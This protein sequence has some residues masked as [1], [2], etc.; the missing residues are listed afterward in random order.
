MGGYDG[1]G[2]GRFG[3][4]TLIADS[5]LLQTQ[6]TGQPIPVW[7][8]GPAATS[9]TIPNSAATGYAS[10]VGTVERP[11]NAVGVTISPFRADFPITAVWVRVRETNES[12]TILAQ[13]K[14]IVA[15][16]LRAETL[17]YV[18]LDATVS[19]ATALFV[20]F[21]CNGRTA[22]L[23]NATPAFF[24]GTVGATITG[25]SMS[26][27]GTLGTLTASVNVHF[28]FALL[29]Y[30]APVRPFAVEDVSQQYNDRSSTFS[31]WAAPCGTIASSFDTVRIPIISN[32]G[33][34]PLTK[35]RLIIRDTNSSGA[36]LAESSLTFDELTV[37]NVSMLTFPLSTTVSG[38][39]AVWLE[40][41][42]DGKIS[43]FSPAAGTIAS[44][45]ARYMTNGALQ[46]G[47]TWTNSAAQLSLFATFLKSV[48]VIP[49]VSGNSGTQATTTAITAH[50]SP[51]FVVPRQ[52]YVI[53]TWN[54]NELSFYWRQ[55]VLPPQ[56]PLRDDDLISYNYSSGG[57]PTVV[58]D[59]GRFFFTGGSVSTGNTI[60][61]TANYG[62]KQVA[63]VTT[64]LN[65]VVNTNGTG[66]TRKVLVIGDS[67]SD[68]AL[69]GDR[70]RWMAELIRLFAA[71]VM[72]IT[73][74]GVKTASKNDS[75][76]TPRTVNGEGRS[77]WTVNQFATDATSP[78]VFSSTFNFATYLST[79]SITM[80]ASD[81]VLFFLGT[82]DIAG[83]LSDNEARGIALG[84]VAQLRTMITSIRAAVSGVRV[85]ICTIPAGCSSQDAFGTTYGGGQTRDRFRRNAV[86][87]NQVMI[88]Q[89]DDLGSVALNQY[90]IPLGNAIDPESGY[91]TTSTAINARD[92]ATY[93]KY[94]DPVHPDA[95]GNWQIADA[96]ATFIKA[97]G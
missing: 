73:Q 88:E 69:A 32:S 60:T 63:R 1:R 6:F 3:V 96:V 97:I 68:M 25:G 34:T 82:N 51:T 95:T 94:T 80:T 21:T 56:V 58:Q 71:D 74:I 13:G 38:G 10:P 18:Q 12:G 81:W 36:I 15:T 66:V 16:P 42:T 40:I 49:A 75:T 46:G 86:I 93:A 20:E 52:L 91:P 45:T 37:S 7:E 17:V 78:F 62:A 41:L 92:S 31:A 47:Q 26:A 24:G 64:S 5:A 87:W 33:T 57:N 30:T 79:N 89:F 85:G 39:T 72:A 70:A 35:A 90:L 9:T 14:A 67:I 29:P 8:S 59:A 61:L 55:L 28:K 2:T 48:A 43:F 4:Q 54:T 53:P 83:A 44:P 11:F 23:L 19:T 84:A 27:F 22:R 77:G 65:L 76:A 50:S